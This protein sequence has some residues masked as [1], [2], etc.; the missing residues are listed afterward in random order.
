M[1]RV[2]TWAKMIRPRATNQVTSIEFVIGNRPNLFSTGTAACVNPCSSSAARDSTFATSLWTSTASDDTPFCAGTVAGVSAPAA[3][4]LPKARHTAT[5]R[6]K[7]S[8]DLGI[9][10]IVHTRILDRFKVILFIVV[11][12][13]FLAL[14]W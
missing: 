12:M 8:P 9:C 5:K 11:M 1:S 14:F 4:T 10:T 13:C 7:P 6:S 3:V 2:A